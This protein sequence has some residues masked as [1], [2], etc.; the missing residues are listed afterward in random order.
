MDTPA[1]LPDYL[2]GEQRD[3]ILHTGSPLLVIAGPGSGKTAV[4]TWRVTHLVRAGLFPPESLLVTTFTNKAALELK[5]RIQRNLPDVPVE[6]M[7]VG[8]LHSFCAD[9]LR[10][11]QTRSPLPRGFHI[12]DAPGQ[13]LFVYTRRKALGLNALVKGR[14]YTFFANVLRLFNLATE[15]LVEPGQLGDWCECQ[16]A[17]AEAL[18]A[19][20]AGAKSKTKAKKAAGEFERWC[21]ERVVIEAYAKYIDLL[22]ERD[23]VDLASSNATPTICWRGIRTSSTRCASSTVPSWWTSTRTPTPSRSVS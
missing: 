8:T 2:T 5:D 12:L 16:R 4:I 9:L 19:E 18:A 15:E 13:L 11:Y 14:P 17:D 21:E 1:Y 20:M 6:T 22:R 23:L 7:P 10:Q 3:A